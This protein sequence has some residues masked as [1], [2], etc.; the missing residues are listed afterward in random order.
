MGTRMNIIGENKFMGVDPKSVESTRPSCFLFCYLIESHNDA[1]M[2]LRLKIV[3]SGE[4][5]TTSWPIK[6]LYFTFYKKDSFM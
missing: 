1:L 5:K 4:T 6:K 2:L 3:H